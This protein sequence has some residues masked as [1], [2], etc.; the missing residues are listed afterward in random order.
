MSRPLPPGLRSLSFRA[1]SKD[2][3]PSTHRHVETAALRCLPRPPTLDE[4]DASLSIRTSCD[5]HGARAAECVWLANGPEPT[6]VDEA[7]SGARVAWEVPKVGELCA[8]LHYGP[9]LRRAS[10]VGCPATN[11]GDRRQ[12]RTDSSEDAK[13]FTRYTPQR[14][15]SSHLLGHH[16]PLGQCPLT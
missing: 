7:G 13:H 14:R 16:T 9:N 6:V 3:T 1:D 4:E 11:E 15:A 5:P 10:R 2:S 12:E 8:R